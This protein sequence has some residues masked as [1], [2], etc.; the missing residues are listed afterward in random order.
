M[1]STIPT[2]GAGSRSKLHM[3]RNGVSLSWVIL[4]ILI[5]ATLACGYTGDA[6]GSSE[7]S[8]GDNWILL[9]NSYWYVPPANLEAVFSS[10]SNG[11]T[12]IPITDQTVFH[13]QTYRGGYF[14]GRISTM[15]TIA[16]QSSGPNCFQLVGSVTP[17]GSVDLSFTPTG[18]S[19]VP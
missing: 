1:L 9:A 12:F 6:Q 7:G 8:S 17:E 5:V 3:L 13:I 19:G 14:W 10:I 11:G 15:L 2:N 18:S 4:P 16:G